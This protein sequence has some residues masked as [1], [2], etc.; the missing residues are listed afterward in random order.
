M[1]QHGFPIA[2]IRG[3]T[4]SRL[5]YYAALEKCNTES[6]KYDFHVLIVQTVLTSMKHLLNL[7]KK[8]QHET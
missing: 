2:I 8:D 3:D 6:D 1:L 4:T 5:A 7:V